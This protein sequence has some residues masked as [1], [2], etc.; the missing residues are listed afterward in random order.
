[1]WYVG[2]ERMQAMTGRL[3]RLVGL[4]ALA[5]T[6]GAAAMTPTAADARGFVRVGVGIGLPFYAPYYYAPY[7]APYYTAPAY[8]APPPVYYPPPAAPAAYA[9]PP[10]PPPP[11]AYAD[12]RASTAPTPLSPQASNARQC[13]Q[14]STTT[15]I[16]GSPQ[17]AVGT[18]CL[19][20]D[21]T[22]RIVN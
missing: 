13:R 9:P 11:A 6:L 16:D 19:Q 12:P 8:Y 10:P 22:W 14:Y 3:R 21:G 15:V 20:P 5:L 17:E 18:A 7:Y 4:S 1:M 2:V